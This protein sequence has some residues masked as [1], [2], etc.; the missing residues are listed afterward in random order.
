MSNN[1]DNITKMNRVDRKLILK[2][3]VLCAAVLL[4]A[5]VLVCILFAEELN[6]DAAKR[7][8]KYL[9]VRND[10]TFGVSTFDA[11]SSNRYALLGD[12]LAVISAGGVETFA[13]D[14][15]E[16][17]NYA[18]TLNDPV[19]TGNDDML[20]CYEVGGK[21]LLALDEKDG[22]LFRLTADG[23]FY[24]ADVSHKG[25]IATAASANGY[26]TVLHVYDAKQQEVFR[27][28]SASRF[29]PWC[30]VSSTG[31]Y[32]ASV[33]V[34]ENNG[35][36]EATLLLFKTDE[37]E[38]LHTIALGDELIYDLRFTEDDTLCVLGEKALTFFCA[39]GSVKGEYSLSEMELEAFDLG[40]NGFVLLQTNMNMAGSSTAICSVDEAGTKLGEFA[41]IGN[42]LDISAKGKYA[43]VLTSEELVV[44]R[45]DMSVYAR[46][47]NTWLATGA[48]MRADG[49][50]ILVT[51][52]SAS[53]Y[54]P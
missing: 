46:V 11:H 42:L 38:P 8:F 48:L 52:S 41:V 36:F 3:V 2:I 25:A 17:G 37:E 9:S 5:A 18:L 6:M 51:S 35:S 19:A 40:G 28:F 15:A 47:P 39:D 32:L 14:G 31:E 26:K 7:W 54:I 20:L 10:E 29:M 43:A 44:L 4:V 22:E 53:I 24:D 27:W 1:K 12:G 34:G 23:V 13:D 49:T 33:A 45:R 21:T 16:S 30:A 50:V